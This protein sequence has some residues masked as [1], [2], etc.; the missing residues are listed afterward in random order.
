MNKDKIAVIGAGTMG[1][2]IAHSFAMNGYETHLIDTSEKVLNSALGVID[3][4]LNRMVTKET[5]TAK[6]K[7]QALSRIATFT[8]LETALKGVSL[9]IEAVPENA[10]LK[11]TIFKNMDQYANDSCMLASNTSSI[12]ITS[13]ASQ[14]RKPDRVIGMH[15]MNPVPIMPLVEIIKGYETSES[16]LEKIQE[17]VISLKKT[18]VVVEDYPGFISNRVLI[19][20]INEAIYALY[21]SVATAEEIDTIMRLGMNHPMGPLELADF[22]GLDVVHSIAMVLYDG[23]GRDKYFPCPLLTNMV[24][25]GKLGRKSGEG[26]Y[27]YEKK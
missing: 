18:A 13:L 5:I 15:F 3:Y 27:H 19:P 20:M 8:D 22:I 16:T 26:F 6:E 21:E 1:G 11:K 4:N 23:F 10:E 2:G 12:S 17:Y 25:A 24:K 7:S 14:V 9:C